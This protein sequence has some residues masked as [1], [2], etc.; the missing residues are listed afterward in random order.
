MPFPSGRAAEQPAEERRPAASR[1]RPRGRTTCGRRVSISARRG[2]REAGRRPGGTAAEEFGGREGRGHNITR[3]Q[4]E[5]RVEVGGMMFYKFWFLEE[6]VT[7]SRRLRN[8]LEEVEKPPRGG[9][10]IYKMAIWA[11]ANRFINVAKHFIAKISR[12][13]H[14]HNIAKVSSL[15]PNSPKPRFLQ[16]ER[17]AFYHVHTHGRETR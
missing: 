1:H 8:L 16:R 12:E 3:H 11:M 10:L 9:S 2:T 14:L 7:S 15:S 13:Y 6:L 4:V 17:R 5:M